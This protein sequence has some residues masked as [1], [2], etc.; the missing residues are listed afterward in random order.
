VTHGSSPVGTPAAPL[1]QRGAAT[2]AR[3]AGLLHGRAAPRITEAKTTNRQSVT[4][5][6]GA[7]AFRAPMR[8]RARA[9]PPRAGPHKTRSH[10]PFK[11]KIKQDPIETRARRDDEPNC[12]KT[13]QIRRP[14][15]I[16]TRTAGQPRSPFGSAARVSRSNFKR[17]EGRD[18]DGSR[19]PRRADLERNGR[20]EPHGS[21]EI[22]KRGRG[23]LRRAKSSPS[24]SHSTAAPPP[25]LPLPHRSIHL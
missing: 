2:P 4:D 11:K 25:S 19:F 18:P 5:S 14:P 20:P 23:R 6:R 13:L 21:V 3:A 15:Q 1:Q 22:L 10:F 24:R 9:A 12:A 8:Y 7:P 16:R 17:P